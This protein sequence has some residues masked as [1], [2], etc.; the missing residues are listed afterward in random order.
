M[1]MNDLDRLH[2]LIGVKFKKKDFHKI[3]DCV[4]QCL[5]DENKTKKVTNKF[6][7]NDYIY[8]DVF[9]KED[10]NH[11]KVFTIEL[12]ET[13]RF[14]RINDIYYTRMETY[15]SLKEEMRRE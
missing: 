6:N 7:V 2:E 12:E 10:K 11:D 1:K 3:Q 9:Y 15:K 4:L 8:F 5:Q 13:R 14:L